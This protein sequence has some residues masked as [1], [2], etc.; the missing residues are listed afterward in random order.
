MKRL[1]NKMAPTVEDTFVAKKI[2]EEDVWEDTVEEVKH[3]KNYSNSSLEEFAK[4]ELGEDETVI[5]LED[6]SHLSKKLD[7]NLL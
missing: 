7:I 2:S 1:S 6:Y 5:I 3:M 4:D